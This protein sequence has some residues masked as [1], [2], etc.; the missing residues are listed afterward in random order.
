VTNYYATLVVDQLDPRLRSGMTAN[1]TVVVQNAAGVLT[2]PNS[3]ITRIGGAAFVT[4]LSRDGKTQT[5]QAIQTGTVGD[6][7]TE[8]TGGLNAGDR[9]V[10]PQLRTGTGTTGTTGAAGG[11]GGLGGG[12]VRGL[13]G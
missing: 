7:T 10:R 11:R 5:R 1:A 12:A 3:V 9:V 4:L 8:I 13:G 2:L 6:T